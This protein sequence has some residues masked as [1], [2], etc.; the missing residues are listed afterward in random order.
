MTSVSRA[1][2]AIVDPDN[3]IPEGNEFNN[4]DSLV[5]EVAVDGLNAFNELTIE[6]LQTDPDPAGP[7]V[8]TN[9]N[10]TYTI[11][12][13]N[14]GT[15]PVIGVHV[16]DFL[17][18]G[19]RFRQA[20]ADNGFFCTESG[21]V[22][23][24]VGGTLDG[25]L[26]LLPPPLGPSVTITIKVFAP[27]TP[28]SFPNQTIVDPDNTIPEGNEFN[29]ADSVITEVAVG[30][31]NAFNELTLSKE[32]SIDDGPD[33]HVTP[34]GM[35]TYTLTIENTGSDP[36][37][38]VMVRDFLPAGTTFASAADTVPGDGAFTCNESGG[39]VECINGTLPGGGG[40][41]IIE[42]A[43]LAPADIESLAANKSNI[44]ISII[45]QAKVDPD[46]DIPE[47]DETNNSD[48]EPTTVKSDINLTID[49]KFAQFWLLRTRDSTATGVSILWL[50]PGPRRGR[51]NDA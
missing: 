42:I 37:F 19:S 1:N 51:Q 23:D 7:A 8:A 32:D 48:S 9:G 43:V 5:T 50:S 14:T 35:I 38:H 44:S 29:N 49:K 4:A 28:G 40:M 10:L 18:T 33:D 30:G 26:D 47:G 31:V 41:R 34:G 20:T 22:V 21:G 17:P 3:T 27:P 25:S 11:T 45:N 15:D 6:K 24:C 13:G 36:A 2:Q 12:V 16:R 39:V 46:N